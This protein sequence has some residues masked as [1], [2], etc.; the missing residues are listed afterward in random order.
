MNTY[1]TG[2]ERH[3]RITKAIEEIT[4]LTDY[5]PEKAFQVIMANKE[6][7]IPYLREAVEYALCKRKELEDGYQL[8]FYAL[9][10]LGQFQDRESFAKIV[11][12]VS[13]PGD[14]VE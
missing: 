3:E 2:E 10:L 8:H 12:F 6:E 7:A 5:F 13:L 1:I 9:F 4:Y 14:D 11:E